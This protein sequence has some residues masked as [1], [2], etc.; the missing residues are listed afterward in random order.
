MK[1][2]ISEWVAD[3][4]VFLATFILATASCGQRTVNCGAAAEAT[5]Q[6]PSR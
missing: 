3:V 4:F 5:T 2:T 6:A 1:D